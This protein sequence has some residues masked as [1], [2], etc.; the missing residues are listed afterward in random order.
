[1]G[2]ERRNEMT[3]PGAS[4][5]KRE[6]KG[7]R[8]NGQ[9][10]LVMLVVAIAAF[11][12]WFPSAAS[13]DITPTASTVYSTNQAG[14]HGDYTIIQ[15]FKYPTTAEPTTG[16]ED[17]KK[18]V[19]DSPAGLVGNPNAI[20]EADRCDPAAFDPSGTM[21][22]LNATGACPAS[23]KVGEALVYLVSDAQDGVCPGT[24]YFPAG[25]CLPGGANVTTLTGNI[26]L[27]KN[28]PA[29]PEVPVVLGTIF[30]NSTSY[31]AGICSLR[32]PSAS[33]PCT[34][35]PKTKSLLEPVTTDDI[36]TTDG[37]FRIR[38]VPEEYS[39][40]P[41][42]YLPSPPFI[43]YTSGG[44]PLHIRR[45]DQKLFGYV[46]NDTNNAP[47]LSFPTN[48]GPWVSKSYAHAYDGNGTAT[49]TGV[50]P[51]NMS[52]AYTVSN[53]DVKSDVSCTTPP[54]FGSSATMTLSD[55]T[56]GSHPQVDVAVK[57][58][59]AFG[60]DYPKKVVSTLPG[61]INV[62][63]AN[64]PADICTTTQRAAN[65]CPAGSKVG[66]ATASTPLL[67]GGL[68]GDV[69]MVKVGDK[70]VP[71]LAVFF[72][73]P[74]NSLRP[75]RMDGET[76][77]V[78]A[79]NN[80]IETT[81]DNAPQNPITEFKLTLNGGPTGLL[82]VI[83]CP[84]DH[85]S[86][87]DG[88]ITFSLTGF[89]GQAAS[90]ANTPALADCFGIAKLKKVSKCVRSKLKVSPS[91]QSRD[92]IAKSELWIKRKGSKKYKRIKTLKKS[93]FRFSVKLNK[94]TYKKGKHAYKIRAV[95]KASPA[96]P[97]GTIKQRTSSFKKC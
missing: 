50:D 75:F 44:T 58:I 17:L 27:L 76:K 84:S 67:S 30:T 89:S 72:N 19:V 34:L 92:Q 26:Y 69:Y 10:R 74:P 5:A 79:N 18:W 94:R 60:D 41:V 66:T 46:N 71:D 88:P 40:R 56:R 95:Y 77:Y 91:Y 80:Q 82:K 90:S 6:K 24:G 20:A 29:A 55:L 22:P 52:D 48:C 2:V 23:S 63:A 4:P 86:P 3:Y 11:A 93:P 39:S 38:T 31:Q 35:Q 59:T 73:N 81:F 32:T 57:G 87:E 25:S 70:V 47:F 1:M 78:G 68:S 28:S 96:A 37:D 83:E 42:A 65:A 13:A 85:L 33:A 12:A 7:A 49:E 61:S 9:F 14:A 97:T 21:S 64:I 54:T 45:I 36:D 51:N 16:T 53:E 62:D 8:V 15:E 43:A